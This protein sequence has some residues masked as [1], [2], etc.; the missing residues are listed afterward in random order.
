MS[1]IKRKEYLKYLADTRDREF[2]R[3][4][5]S[6]FPDRGAEE[7]VF[8]HG[9]PELVFETRHRVSVF[10]ANVQRSIVCHD[11]LIQQKHADAGSN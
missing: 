10:S 3:C 9:R 11:D 5:S 2:Q 8:Q 7:T 1:G 6:G 4:R